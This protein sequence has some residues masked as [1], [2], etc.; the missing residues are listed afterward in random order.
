[1]PPQ[2]SDERANHPQPQSLFAKFLRLGDG[3]ILRFQINLGWLRLKQETRMEEIERVHGKADC[4]PVKNIKIRFVPY[5]ATSPTIR[6]FDGS[7]NRPEQ[8]VPVSGSPV[9]WHPS[10]AYRI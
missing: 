5:D 8:T 3:R 4:T 7:V 10:A 1:M 2:T 9:L 6:K